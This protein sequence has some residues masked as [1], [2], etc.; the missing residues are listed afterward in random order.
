MLGG[1][2][3]AFIAKYG[4]PTSGSDASVGRLQF[5]RF[6]NS[7]I[8][9]LIV[10]LDIFDGST[11]SDRAYSITAQHPPNQP[12]SLSQAQNICRGLTPSDAHFVKTVLITTPSGTEGVDEQ[13]TSAALASIFPASAFVGP[14]QEPVTPG[15]FDIHFVY[16]SLGNN[17]LIDSCQLEVGLQQAPSTVTGNG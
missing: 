13:Y 12:W 16:T 15:S 11:V 14:T 17:S 4:Q 8:D 9:F 7:N 1:T 10:Q 3:A 5:Q 6:P 2:Q